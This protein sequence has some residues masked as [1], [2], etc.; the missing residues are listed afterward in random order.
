M[1]TTMEIPDLLIERA[2]DLAARDN[3]T[4]K[5]LVERGLRT[6]IS[7]AEKKDAVEFALR[8]AS[9]D[10]DGLQ[11]EMQGATWERWRELAYGARGG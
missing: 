2:R 9:V 4:L 7:E 8:D 11:P 5:E 1:K 6:V 3:T 10:G